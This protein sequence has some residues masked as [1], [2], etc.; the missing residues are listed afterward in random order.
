MLAKWFTLIQFAKEHREGFALLVRMN[1]DDRV[2][3]H[4]RH[5]L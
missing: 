5:Y 4:K 3:E 1:D 2:E